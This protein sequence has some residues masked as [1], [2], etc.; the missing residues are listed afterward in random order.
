MP[1]RMIRDLALLLVL[2]VLVTSASSSGLVL[3]EDPLTSQKVIT[4]QTHLGDLASSSS[5]SVTVKNGILDG[6]WPPPEY[7]SFISDLP[8]AVRSPDPEPAPGPCQPGPGPVRS[9]CP[10][11]DYQLRPGP[12]CPFGAS[13]GG[14]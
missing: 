1:G 11:G 5:W 8:A 10:F 4:V 7:F 3:T 13:G 6:T 14:S 2:V 9:L 12:F